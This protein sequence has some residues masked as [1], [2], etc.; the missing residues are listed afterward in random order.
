[1]II[2]TF[3]KTNAPTYSL[4]IIGTR[5]KKDMVDRYDAV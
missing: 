5:Q 1:M 3:I 4:L 2:F